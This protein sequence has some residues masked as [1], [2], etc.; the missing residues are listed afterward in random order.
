MVT[1]YELTVPTYSRVVEATI[2]IM[3]KGLAYLKE[4]GVDPSE[5]VEMRLAEDM[6]PFSGQVNILYHQATKGVNGL[7]EGEFRPPSSLEEMDYQ[8]LIDYLQTALES[9]KS[10]NEEELNA[11]S[12]KPVYFKFS[13]QSVPFTTENFAMSFITPNL[14][15]H[16][17]TIY[18]MLRIKGVPL[19]KREFLGQM[20]IGIPE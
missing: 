20:K 12:G 3:Q 2:G 9:L 15:F 1:L 8:G 13:D 19:S 14:Y 18:D 5:V 16:A 7:I 11:V 10:V 17:V 6:M 4:N